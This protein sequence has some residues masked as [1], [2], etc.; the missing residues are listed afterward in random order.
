MMLDS[1]PHLTTKL[2][3]VIPCT[4]TFYSLYYF[5]G[6][7]VYYWIYKFYSISSGT[8]FNSPY[9]VNRLEMK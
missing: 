1:A 4:N 7:M 8:T 6:S 2:P 9:F 3:F 5:L